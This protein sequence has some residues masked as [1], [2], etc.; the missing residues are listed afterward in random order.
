MIL[1][2]RKGSLG[3]LPGQL[4]SLKKIEQY[5]HR[6]TQGQQTP[7]KLAGGWLSWLAVGQA[8]TAQFVAHTSTIRY[9][10]SFGRSEHSGPGLSHTLW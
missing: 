10:H 2:K 1:S 4:A 8:A 6:H 5:R 7:N 3:I 9:F